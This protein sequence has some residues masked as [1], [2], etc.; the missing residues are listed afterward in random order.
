MS[1]WSKRSP[2]RARAGTR[3][4]PGAYGATYSDLAMLPLGLR[5]LEILRAGED[6]HG[7]DVKTRSGRYVFIAD[8]EGENKILPE[9]RE[10]SARGSCVDRN[11]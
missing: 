8:T 9:C 5:T 11:F 2:A 6:T 4:P 7:H 3:R 1:S 10:T